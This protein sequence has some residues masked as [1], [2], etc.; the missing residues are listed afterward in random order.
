MIFWNIA[1]CLNKT[2]IFEMISAQSVNLKTL[3]IAVLKLSLDPPEA[4]LDE[5][6]NAVVTGETRRN[7]GDID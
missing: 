5:N 7:T 2:T 4:S 6:L 1:W 3:I